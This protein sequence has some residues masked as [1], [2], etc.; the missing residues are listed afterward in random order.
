V[1]AKYALFRFKEKKEIDQTQFNS[2][3]ENFRLSLLQQKQERVF[4]GWLD[5]LLE[6]AKAEGHFKMYKEANEIL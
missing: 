6:R 4:T 5:S 3:K 1:T 2:Q